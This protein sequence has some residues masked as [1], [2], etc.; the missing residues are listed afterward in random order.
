MRI[1]VYGV[2]AVGG[3]FGGRL[4]Q[5]GEDVVFIARGKALEVLREGGLTVSSILGNFKIDPARAEARPEDVGPVD[6]VFVAVK[7]WQV[8]EAAEAMRPLV[9]PRTMVVPLQNGVEA[10]DQLAAV[11]GKERVV[12]GLCRILA[13]QGG[14]GHVVHA[15]VEPVIEFAEMDGSPSERIENLRAAFARC[16]GLMVKVPADVRAALWRKFA[17]IASVGGVGAVTRASADVFRAVPETRRMLED[18]LREVLAVGRAH[19]AALPDQALAE[20]MKFIDSLPKGATA[21][22]QRDI[23]DGR[24]SELVAQ[25]GAVVRLGKAKGVPTPVNEVLYAALLPSEKRA[26]ETPASP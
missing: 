7:A 26:R 12:G 13:Y 23:M 15:G 21:S 11:L 14:P 6:V 17:F 25:T 9:G 1:A 8:T 20:T 16:R 3:Y 18:A 4:A 22:M 24:P 19:G 5:A 2:G 10:F